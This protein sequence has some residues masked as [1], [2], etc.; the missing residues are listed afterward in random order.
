MQYNAVIQLLGGEKRL[1]TEIKNDIDLLNLSYEGL[2]KN[3][4]ESLLRNLDLSITEL[5]KFNIFPRSRRTIERVKKNE[6]LNT[7]IS[8][9]IIKLAI[10][11]VKGVNVFGD[12][13]KFYLWLNSENRM[14]G[15]RKPM[16]LIGNYFGYELIEKELTNIEYG[17]FA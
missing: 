12:K 10:L 17:I 4:L 5:A 13:E 8:Q 16:E 3:A 2:P 9:S 11:Y 7:E 14:F 1:N 6:K 15:G